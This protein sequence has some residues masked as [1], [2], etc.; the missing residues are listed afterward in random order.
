MHRRPSASGAREPISQDPLLNPLLPLSPL[1]EFC[2]CNKNA[3]C[4][5][6]KDELLN[7]HAFPIHVQAQ[8]SP[9]A[10]E[11]SIQNYSG[12]F[13][14]AIL[15]LIVSTTISAL[16]NF[17]TYGLLFVAIPGHSIPTSDFGY[18]AFFNLFCSPVVLLMGYFLES[19]PG[20]NLL[21]IANIVALLIISAVLTWSKIDHVLPG[22]FLLCSSIILSMK[23]TSFHL[24]LRDL[25]AIELL[26]AAKGHH[27]NEMTLSSTGE[28][29][30]DASSITT[31]TNSNSSSNGPRLS[32]LH[33]FYFWIAP[34]LCFQLQYPR[35]GPFR[36]R[37]FVS[38][39]FELFS[40]VAMIYILT[41]QYAVPTVVNSTE[42]LVQLDFILIIERLLLLSMSNICIWLLLF[43]AIFHS[44][45]NCVS[46]V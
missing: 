31:N 39:L 20:L 23:L 11:S 42:H 12:L 36:W 18:L 6:C 14:L 27:V 29:S 17:R 34:T 21:K 43:Y 38:R 8:P 33:M 7:T 44:F 24:V 46:E 5:F 16:E 10:S 35:S 1:P 32:I 40:C 25:K 19:R 45:L 26:K 13:N 22:V 4:S 28:A 15:M 41:E 37:Y 3:L 30:M 2:S 9:L